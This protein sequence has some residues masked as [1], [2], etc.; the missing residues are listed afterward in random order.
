MSAENLRTGSVRLKDPTDPRAQLAQKY[1]TLRPQPLERWLWAQRIPPAAER[2]FW[3]HWQE[4]AKRGDWCSELPLRCVARDCHLDVS[5][6]TRAYQ[7]LVRTGCLRRTDPGRDPANPFNQATPITEV[8]VPRE[9]LVELDRHPNRGGNRAAEARSRDAESAAFP[10]QTPAAAA[11][12]PFAGQTGRDRLRSLSSLTRML[13]ADE[14][15]Q[16]DEA[17]RLRRAHL[18]FDVDSVV[19]P[20]DRAKVLQHL[21][22]AA[23]TRTA[24][25]V[26]APVRGATPVAPQPRQLSTFEFARLRRDIQAAT[27]SAAAPELARQVAWSVEEGALRRFGPLHATRIALKK[28][29]EGGWTR[30]NRMPPNWS[31]A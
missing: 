14:R 31:R 29:R 6:V 18:T 4:G 19:S 10:V 9:L 11:A 16:Y 24:S 8:R 23:A 12:D 7:W 22:V 20:E 15:R 28:I 1:F 5:T 13:S 26:P 21:S 17:L 30:P 2:V 25:R 27:S 3:R